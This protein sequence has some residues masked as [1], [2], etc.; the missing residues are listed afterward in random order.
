[1][2]DNKATE[3]NA[4][5]NHATGELERRRRNIILRAKIGFSILGILL[6]TLILLLV[7]SP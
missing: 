4:L 7:L 5:M 2:N 3:F 1:M 6:L